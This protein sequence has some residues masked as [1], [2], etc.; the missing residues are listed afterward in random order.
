[1]VQVGEQCGDEVVEVFV[2]EVVH[3]RGGFGLLLVP[4]FDECTHDAG[5]AARLHA[6]HLHHDVGGV[7]GVEDVSQHH[8]V[9]R[10][11]HVH[12]GVAVVLGFVRDLRLLPLVELL[13]GQLL[14]AIGLLYLR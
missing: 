1:V 9:G 3:L 12:D 10:V 4:E 8:A 6:Q 5:C 2:E 13:E 11:L 14:L 7:L